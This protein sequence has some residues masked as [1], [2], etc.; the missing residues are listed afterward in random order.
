MQDATVVVIGAGAAG[1][2]AARQLRENGCKNVIVL[3]ANNR[4]G[5]PS[6]RVCGSRWRVACLCPQQC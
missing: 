2:M 1:V 5:A 3:E 6:E 4:I